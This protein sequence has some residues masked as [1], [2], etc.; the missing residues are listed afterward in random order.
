MDRCSESIT[1]CFS[2]IADSFYWLWNSRS[3]GG[4]SKKIIRPF[5]S[6]VL[7]EEHLYPFTPAITCASYLD[8][9]AMLIQCDQIEILAFNVFKCC[10][11][12]IRSL[13]S[14]VNAGV[15]EA[16]MSDRWGR[17]WLWTVGQRA[18]SN[19]QGSWHFIKPPT[20]GKSQQEKESATERWMTSSNLLKYYM[21]FF[22]LVFS[23]ENSQELL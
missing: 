21:L 12:A 3:A 17:S 5:L 8:C 20:T 13:R 22:V 16:M 11:I 2:N 6:P 23:S 4:K 10:P 14:H 15:Q 9:N 19:R 18:E 1:L 7:M